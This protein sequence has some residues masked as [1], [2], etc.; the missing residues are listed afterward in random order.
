MPNEPLKPLPTSIEAANKRIHDH[1]RTALETIDSEL[2]AGK[3]RE[4]P[5]L[6]AAYLQSLATYSA[7]VAIA[8][9]MARREGYVPVLGSVS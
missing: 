6:V 7:G 5:E 8:D 2:G 4:H 3:A 1:F 9:A